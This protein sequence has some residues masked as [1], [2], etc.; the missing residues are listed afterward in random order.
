MKNTFLKAGLAST[1]LAA[2]AVAGSAAL[3]DFTDES[4][5]TGTYDVQGTASAS[6]TLANGITWELLP[7]PASWELTYAPAPAGDPAPLAGDND[8]VG[9][10]APGT[11][12][13]EITAPL[14]MLTL[15]FSEKVILSGLFFLDLF[16]DGASEAEFAIVNVDGGSDRTFEA[17]ETFVVGG[18]G[19]G[20]FSTKLVGTSFVFSVGNT[21]DDVASPDYALAGVDVA[22]IP[23]PAGLL[24]M[25]TAL[26]GL[27]VAR[28]TKKA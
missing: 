5:A 27:G 3:L 2:S 25:G 22:P 19:F 10:Q 21:N 17:Y 1:F 6:G 11:I 18:L 9:V 24:L 15:T 7:T 28:R 8:G 23:L 13:D 12:N 14:E 26:A 16:T 20:E 4:M